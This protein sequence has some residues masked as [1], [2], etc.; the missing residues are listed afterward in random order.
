[1]AVITDVERERRAI[2]LTCC[3][4]GKRDICTAV[5]WTAQSTE[6][7]DKT[8]TADLMEYKCQDCGLSFWC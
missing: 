1:M 7:M 6:P 3:W 8:N 5:V 4:C 2:D